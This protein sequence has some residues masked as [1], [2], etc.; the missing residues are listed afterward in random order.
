MEPL[1]PIRLP[2]AVEI[3]EDIALNEVD[4]AIALVAAGAAVRVRIAGLREPVADQLAGLA[5]ART[6][7][8]HIAFHVDRSP[9]AVTFTVGP[10]LRALPAG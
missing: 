3:E 4:V 2:A 9:D 7:A 8:A 10:Q 5:A 6:A 1:A